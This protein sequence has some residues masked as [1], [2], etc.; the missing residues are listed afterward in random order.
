MKKKRRRMR[1]QKNPSILGIKSRST[2]NKNKWMNISKR[3][4]NLKCISIINLLRNKKQHKNSF[5]IIILKQNW[6]IK[7][8]TFSL[9]YRWIVMQLMFTKLITKAKK[10]MED[11]LKSKNLRVCS[12]ISVFFYFV[13]F[14]RKTSL[15]KERKVVIRKLM[16]LFGE[17]IKSL[18]KH[19]IAMMNQ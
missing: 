15:L 11:Y 13:S 1:N 6:L 7:K 12:D 17:I 10:V 5:K 16:L 8:M 4:K 18:F 9:L 14:T 3:L 2:Q 19:Q